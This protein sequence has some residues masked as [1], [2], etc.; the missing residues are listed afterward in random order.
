MKRLLNSLFRCVENAETERTDSGE[1][2]LSTYYALR[3][4][5]NPL[6]QLR[7]NKRSRLDDFAE[8]MREFADRL[9]RI[10]RA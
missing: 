10:G 1:S 2:V 6:Q 9:C 5:I 7:I 3:F 8:V 4:K